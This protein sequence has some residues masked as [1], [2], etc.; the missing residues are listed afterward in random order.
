MY[1]YTMYIYMNMCVYFM[2]EGVVYGDVGAG[3][4]VD[5]LH[6][7]TEVGS[8][9]IMI[10]HDTNDDTHCVH[11]YI[12]IYTHTMLLYKVLRCYSRETE[13][14]MIYLQCYAL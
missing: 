8:V 6:V 5:P 3:Q 14:A 4:T 12:Y 2:V 13:W 9:S 7:E 11:I 10:L 1:N